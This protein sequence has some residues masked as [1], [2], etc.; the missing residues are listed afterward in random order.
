MRKNNFWERLFPTKHDFYQMLRLQAV[1][2]AK[3][4]AYLDSWIRVGS[5]EDYHQ[6]LCEAENADQLRFEMEDKLIEAFAT[7]FDRQDI[8]SV[9]NDM[10]KIVEYAKSTLLEIEAFEMKADEVIQNMVGELMTGTGNLAEAIGLLKDN[11]LK[12]Q[13]QIRNIRNIQQSIEEKYRAG[14]A[15]MFKNPDL[16]IAL[17]YREVYHHIKDAQVSLGD[18]TDTLHRIIMRLV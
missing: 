7:P 16:M 6:L 15:L 18:T 13:M 5:E 10:D 14:M 11:P 8:Y 17:K 4:I 9:S 12:A 1:T 2:S 3:V